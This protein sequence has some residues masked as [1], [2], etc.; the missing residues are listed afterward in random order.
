MEVRVTIKQKFLNAAAGMLAAMAGDEEFEQKVESARKKCE[1]AV[2]EVDVDDFKQSEARQLSI[3]LAMYAMGKFLDT[4][5]G[6]IG[7]GRKRKEKK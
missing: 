7:L 6:A 3:A 2:V 1:N 5:D 4:N